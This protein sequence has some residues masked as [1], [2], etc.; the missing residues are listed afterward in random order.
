MGRSNLLRNEYESPAEQLEIL[1]KGREKLERGE[2]SLEAME[3]GQQFAEEIKRAHIVKASPSW[4]N[5]K[6]GYGLFAE[7][8][9]QPGV[10]IGEYTGIVRK[11]NRLYMEPMNHYCYEYPI[12]DSIGRSYVIDATKGNLTRFINHSE[13]P[14]LRPAYAFLDGAYH[15]IFFSLCRIE[16]GTQLSYHYGKSYWYIRGAPEL[17]F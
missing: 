8:V 16:I 1:R 13:T 3:L 17:L 4:I 12:L 14:N 5:D 6:V 7:E 10:F 15:C 2:V 11:N 9:I